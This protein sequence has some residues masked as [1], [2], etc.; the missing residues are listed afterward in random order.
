MFTGEDRFRSIHFQ[1]QFNQFRQF[2]AHAIIIDICL[3]VSTCNRSNE[4]TEYFLSDCR[5]ILI[6]RR[7]CFYSII[8]IRNDRGC[9]EWLN[10][11]SLS[12]NKRISFTTTNGNGRHISHISYVHFSCRTMLLRLPTAIISV[13]LDISLL[14]CASFMSL[15]WNG[16]IRCHSCVRFSYNGEGAIYARHSMHILPKSAWVL[17][18]LNAPFMRESFHFIWSID[19]DHLLPLVSRLIEPWQTY[20]QIPIR[21]CT[22][23]PLRWTHFQ[24]VSIRKFY[25]ISKACRSNNPKQF[26]RREN[27]RWHSWKTEILG[28]KSF[29]CN[30]IATKWL[31]LPVLDSFLWTYNGAV[32]VLV[33]MCLWQMN[34]SSQTIEN[35]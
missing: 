18:S 28:G 3:L 9:M 13:L 33:C 27:H 6:V 1:Y 32:T 31:L 15:S 12:T 16:T 17:G 11:Q 25:Q 30:C 23:I 5:L 21:P 2:R 20:T 7:F 14:F 24:F 4:T 34:I 19:D 8:W 35:A 10:E 26:A 22:N 29:I